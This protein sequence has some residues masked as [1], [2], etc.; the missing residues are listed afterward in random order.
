MLNRE[1]IGL[2]NELEAHYG[3]ELAAFIKNEE[4]VGEL[5]S[6][7]YD[8]ARILVHDEARQRVG[9]VPMG[10]FL[11]AT[12][13]EPNSKPLAGQEDTSL[14]LLRVIGHSQLPDRIATDNWRYDAA[15][16]AMDYPQTYDA[17]EHI[18]PWTL[19][20]LRRAGLLCRVLGTFRYVGAGD[21]WHLAFGADV[22]NFYSG[23]GMKIYKPMG[24]A[25]KRVIN[26]SKPTG[27]PH[28][29]A[30]Q[31]VPVG[32][33]R[34]AAT[35]IQVSEEREN[36]SVEI[37]PTDM[38]AR[39]TA[40]FGMSRSGKSNTIK[41]LATAIF[42]LRERDPE[43]GRV[44]QLIFDMNG[45]YCNDNPQDEGCLRNVSKDD[46]VTY[47]MF[48]HPN[49]PGRRLIKLN[50]YGEEPAN[51]RNLEEV[52]TALASLITGKEII[53]QHLRGATQ[54]AQY[55][56]G[57]IEAALDLPELPDDWG[58]GARVRYQRNITIYRSFLYKA[59]FKPPDDL[60]T[61]Y[62]KGL[63]SQDFVKALEAG[64]AEGKYEKAV[65]AL[66]KDVVAWDE[67]YEAVTELREFITGSSGGN[68]DQSYIAFNRKYQDRPGGSG[69]P[70]SN[71]N[72]R[73]F[74]SFSARLGGITRIRELQEK[75]HPDVATVYEDEIVK[76]LI[77]GKLVIVDQSVGAESE[78]RQASERIMWSIFNHQVKDFTNPRRDN[79][80]GGDIIPLND[81]IVYVEEAHNLIPAHDKELKSA[82]ART[83][84]EGSKFRI[85]LVYSTQEP[86]S[87]LSNILKNTDNWFI[88][89]LNSREETRKLNDYYDFEDF[90]SQII[91]VPDTGYVRMRC[92]SNPYMV[93]VQIDE[94]K[95]NVPG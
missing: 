56:S 63:F 70:Y 53:D 51:W 40:L 24:Y 8:E 14:I 82:W 80:N 89:H 59:G 67:M 41:V 9:G 90:A 91:R 36:V 94:F 22:S 83:A 31:Q 33:V 15:S 44:G 55:V 79:Q 54:V 86:S 26:F 34:Y 65:S 38:I 84:K 50:F 88:A 13:I 95:A 87:I 75:H 85:G 4:V 30:G 19:N 28:P 43:K 10:C 6:L 68:G 27:K 18:D 77:Q 37:E 73:G 66:K 29:L 23:Q 39:R 17:E 76:E 21:N 49:D 58:D 16:R 61:A 93:P 57:F 52:R 32:R 71:A 12:R 1:V 35:E 20:Q 7:D 47:G 60:S 64:N 48:E 42:K 11:V 46:V 25:L 69:E 5:L 2:H 78:V 72:M 74:L 45:E 81:I 92:L 62:I 3:G